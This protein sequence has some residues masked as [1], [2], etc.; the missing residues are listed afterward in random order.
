MKRFSKMKTIGAMLLVAISLTACSSDDDWL[1]GDG[2]GTEQGPNAPGDSGNSG[3]VTYSSSISDLMSFDISLDKSTLTETETIPTE[4]DE[5]QWRQHL[6][7]G[8]QQ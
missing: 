7:D 6:C 2:N 3:N 4:G 1:D 8:H 5:H